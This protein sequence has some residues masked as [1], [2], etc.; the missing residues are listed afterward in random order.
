MSCTG[1]GAVKRSDVT[2]NQ[3]TTHHEKKW[4]SSRTTFP[5]AAVKFNTGRVEIRLKQETECSVNNVK[6]GETDCGLATKGN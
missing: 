2:T 3:G 5:T 1:L 4:H 6:Q